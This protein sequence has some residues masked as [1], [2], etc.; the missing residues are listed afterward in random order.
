MKLQLFRKHTGYNIVIFI[1]VITALTVPFA[2][3]LS[4]SD[5][6]TTL[7]G[8]TIHANYSFITSNNLTCINGT[9]NYKPVQFPSEQY[10]K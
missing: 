2:C 6:N 8:E 5:C 10:W 7:D 3:L 9:M 4:V 1:V